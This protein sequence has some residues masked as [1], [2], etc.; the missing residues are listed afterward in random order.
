M[1]VEQRKWQSNS[2]RDVDDRVGG[3][4][5]ELPR[6]ESPVVPAISMPDKGLSNKQKEK[7]T[8]KSRPAWA[9]TE[10][11]KEAKEEE[12]VDKLLDF[13]SSLDFDQYLDDLEVRAA[14]EQVRD[15][16]LCHILHKWLDNVIRYRRL[17]HA[18]GL[19]S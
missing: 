13:A 18:S 8:K 5:P 3:S 7:L 2:A 19:S 6:R 9:M 1:E 10:E 17:R 11:M 14:L 15:R 16:L 4:E 12:D